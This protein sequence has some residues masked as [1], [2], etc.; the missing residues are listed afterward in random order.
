M[1]RTRGAG[2][3][4]FKDTRL[5]L[6]FNGA[7]LACSHIVRLYRALSSAYQES[8]LYD[9]MALFIS[10]GM[11]SSSY[12]PPSVF[13]T[14]YSIS[15]DTEYGQCARPG[16]NRTASTLWPEPRST[17]PPGRLIGE[18]PVSEWKCVFLMG[19]GWFIRIHSRLIDSDFKTHVSFLYFSFTCAG[20][21]MA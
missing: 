13:S 17:R 6:P 10:D 19:P 12:L 21:P 3:P 16:S 8:F 2:H 7:H 15:F 1:R 11:R 9:A 20:L 14:P 18:P 5:A 4:P